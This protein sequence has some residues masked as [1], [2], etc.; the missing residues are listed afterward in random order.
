MFWKKIIPP[1]DTKVNIKAPQSVTKGDKIKE[2][3]GVV[4]NRCAERIKAHR[5]KVSR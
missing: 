5:D 4:M 3:T 2:L 1:S